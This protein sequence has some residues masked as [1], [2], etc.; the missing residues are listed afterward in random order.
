MSLYRKEIHAGTL[1]VTKRKLLRFWIW[2]FNH[3]TEDP[4]TAL[5]NKRAVLRV[6]LARMDKQIPKMEKAL[7]DA[8]KKV[9]DQ[10]GT[11][12]PWRAWWSPERRPV[13]AGDPNVKLEKRKKE[14]KS[15]PAPH[16]LASI[17]AGGK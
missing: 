7:Q 11:S 2:S 12:H 3:S 14:E 10:G 5:R 9:L 1:I 17:V 4:I 15:K 8:A 6:Q 16:V 13:V